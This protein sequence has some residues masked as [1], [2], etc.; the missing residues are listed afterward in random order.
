[1]FADDL[2]IRDLS[3]FPHSTQGLSL[4]DVLC[5]TKTIEGKE[6]LLKYLRHPCNSEEE[7]YSF[8][9]L[10]QSIIHSFES[11]NKFHTLLSSEVFLTVKKQQ[12][13]QLLFMPPL[14]KYKTHRKRQKCSVHTFLE[15]LIEISQEI[16]ENKIIRILSSKLS[17]FKNS[18]NREVFTKI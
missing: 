15:T 7:V 9:N 2:T 4:F 18:S 16:G 10:L 8:Q 5:C 13:N 14:I 3:I 17:V 1:M 12:D 6:Q 11:W